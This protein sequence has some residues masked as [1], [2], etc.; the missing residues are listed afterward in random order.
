MQN[1]PI[2]ISPVIHEYLVSHGYSESFLIS[3][4]AGAGS[5]RRYFRI[6]E[7]NKNCVLQVSAEVNEDFKHFVEYSKT[8]REYGLPVPRVYC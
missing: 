3:P 2:Q 7:G 8:F 4:I 6:A 1:E 5:G